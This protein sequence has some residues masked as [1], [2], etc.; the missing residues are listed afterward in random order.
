A[1]TGVSAS[2]CPGGAVGDQYVSTI[3]T[4]T[5]GSPSALISQSNTATIRPTSSASSMTLSSLK[6]PCT[7][8]GAAGSPGRCSLNHAASASI[9]GSGVV[10]DR[11]QRLDQPRTWRSTK[12]AGLPSALRACALTSIACRSASLSTI[13]SLRR[14]RAGG[15]AS[16]GGSTVATTAPYP[17]FLA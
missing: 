12:P 11:C 15:F 10:L 14:G 5:S 6:S 13:A 17:R 7:T 4:S 9:S 16:F 3:P 1:V 2:C 8:D